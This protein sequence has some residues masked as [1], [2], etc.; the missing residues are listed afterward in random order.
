[1][2]MP[3]PRVYFFR[4]PRSTCGYAPKAHPSAITAPTLTMKGKAM[5]LNKTISALCVVEE[6]KDIE[7]L[8]AERR[9][10]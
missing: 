4:C 8:R 9:V 10:L 6:T 3:S 5:L 7:G 2:Y 1:M